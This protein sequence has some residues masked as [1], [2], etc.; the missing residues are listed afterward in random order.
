MLV[1]WSATGHFCQYDA[2][3]D[4]VCSSELA[5]LEQI[6]GFICMLSSQLPFL[7]FCRRMLARH[8]TGASESC[9]WDS[10]LPQGLCWQA[11][12]FWQPSCCSSHWYAW[13]N[14]C[15]MW[16]F[17]CSAGLGWVSLQSQ[18]WSPHSDLAKR[19]TGC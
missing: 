11:R 19:E 10:S 9:I 8:I 17:G 12:T 14:A 5:A 18:Q 3:I 2:G 4:N 1:Y 7:A 15:D 6:D 13:H 16:L